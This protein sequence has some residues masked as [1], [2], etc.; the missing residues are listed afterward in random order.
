MSSRIATLVTAVL[1]VAAG[2]ADTKSPRVEEWRDGAWKALTTSD[3]QISG[4]RDGAQTSAMAVFTLQ[5]GRKLRV[6][7]SVVYN[8]TPSLAAGHWQMGDAGGEVVAESIKFLGGQ[9][10]GPSLGGRL[11]LEWKG[12]P[13]FLATLPLRPLEQDG[14]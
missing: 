12:S 13:R 7:L 9:G 14:R 10:E 6:E 4:K 11:R 3:Y 1:V 8:P 5:D 2:C